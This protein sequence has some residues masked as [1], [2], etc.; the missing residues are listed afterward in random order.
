[1]FTTNIIKLTYTLYEEHNV[2]KFSHSSTKHTDKVRI[3]NVK[4]LFSYQENAIKRQVSYLPKRRRKTTLDSDNC[5]SHIRYQGQH[6]ATAIP[7]FVTRAHTFLKATK[8]NKKKTCKSK[9]IPYSHSLHEPTQIT[10]PLISSFFIKKKKM[11]M[12]PVFSHREMGIFKNELRSPWKRTI[13][14][15][16]RTV[17]KELLFT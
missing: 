11:E 15:I 2:N 6:W 13:S 16:Q 8:S 14:R 5:K 17:I 1:M 10:W 9:G 12:M 4:V 7:N 3:S